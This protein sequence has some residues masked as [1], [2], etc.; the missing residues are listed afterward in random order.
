V[1]QSLGTLAETGRGQALT[2][3]ALARHPT[4]ISLLK[5]AARTQLIALAIG[6]KRAA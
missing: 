5:H 2:A 6:E 3:R 4:D 1:V